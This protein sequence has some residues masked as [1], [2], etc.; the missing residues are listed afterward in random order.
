M[1]II[2]WNLDYYYRG[3][4]NLRW[5]Y[6]RYYAPLFFDMRDLKNI[7]GGKDVIPVEDF[8]EGACFK[9]FT[10]HFGFLRKSS[11]LIIMPKQYHKLVK[12]KFR[13]FFKKTGKKFDLNGS[14]VAHKAVVTNV[15][16]DIERFEMFEE[17]FLKQYPLTPEQ[18]QLNTLSFDNLEFIF[19][20]N[21]PDQL[22]L[23][24]TLPQ[25]PELLSLA[26][27]FSK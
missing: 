27:D 23:T 13:D 25:D 1:H 24:S 15:I 7:L 16:R 17:E 26:Q 21:S 2:Q 18:E 3:A 12:K 22:P 11:I 6:Q 4:K 9:P 8:G 14:T 19:D 10:A 5:V 20:Q